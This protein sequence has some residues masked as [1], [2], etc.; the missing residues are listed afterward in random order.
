M[1]MRYLTVCGVGLAA[2]L[3]FAP[4]SP[5]KYARVEVQ[6]VPVDRLVTNLEEAVK[7]NPKNVQALVNLA[8]VHGMA[9][10]LKTDTAQVRKGNEERGPWFGYEPKLVPF[11]TVEKTEDAAKQKAANAHLA[12]AVE[13][14]KEA[15]KLAP[16]N[17][18]ARLGYAWTLDQS[19]EKKQAVKEYRALIEDAW[20]NEKDLK[21][22][23][24]GGHTVVAEATEYLIPLLNKEKDKKE[25]ATLTGRAAQLRKL[26][27]PITPIA[28]PLRDGLLAQDI[29]DKN[30]IVAFD[31][32]G[33]GLKRKWTWVR[34]DAGWLVYDS[35]SKRN[36]TSTLQLFGNVTFWL[37]WETGYDALASLD[38]NG[39]GVLTG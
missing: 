31:A 35:K 22:L 11:S 29:E 27:R 37:F 3:L 30:A 18:R 8:R 14:F 24:L 36:I 26:P 10:A 23:D 9:Y 39:D 17:L 25:I 12:K 1:G 7:K 32:D 38:D 34:K 19:G 13:R 16:D 4:A 15:V 21:E 28:E 20:K 33:S 5:G 6:Q 2:C